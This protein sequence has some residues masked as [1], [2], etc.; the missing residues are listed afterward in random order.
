[1]SFQIFCSKDRGATEH[2]K[3]MKL[4]YDVVVRCGELPSDVY[5]EG[6]VDLHG[7]P[8]DTRATYALYIGRYKGGN[9]LARV[10]CYT[11]NYNPWEVDEVWFASSLRFNNQ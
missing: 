2:A 9:V 10:G 4:S 8:V 1:M 5:I 7:C 6:G 3:Y 11:N